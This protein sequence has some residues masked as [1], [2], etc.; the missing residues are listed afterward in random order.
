MKKNV[1]FGDNAYFQCHSHQA[2]PGIPQ[3]SD[4]LPPRPVPTGAVAQ[5]VERPL[6]MREVPSSILGSSTLLPSR[7]PHHHVRTEENRLTRSFA[8]AERSFLHWEVPSSILGS[9]TSVSVCAGG[10]VGR[11]GGP[12]SVS[13][14]FIVCDIYVLPWL[15][16]LHAL[17]RPS[18][19]GCAHHM[20]ANSW[21]W[22]PGPEHVTRQKRP[23]ACL[24][25]AHPPP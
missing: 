13:P 25:C 21:C 19:A 14:V 17:R 23:S 2:E 10:W 6:S 11:G 12:H 1:F 20:A 24:C 22:P 18:G 15:N 7:G 8:M 4:V 9:S 3:V 5:M 16:V